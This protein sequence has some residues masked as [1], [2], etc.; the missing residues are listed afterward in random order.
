MHDIRIQNRNLIGNWLHNRKL[1]V[2]RNGVR[3]E[4]LPVMCG[5]PQ[6]SVLG[7]VLFIIHINDIDTNVSSSVHMFADDTKLYSNVC[8]CDQT[9]HPQCDLDKMSAWS[10]KWQMLFNADE[11]KRLHVGHSYHSVT[12]SIGGVEI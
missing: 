8:T 2:V 10:T 4:W 1:R 6:G 5:V 11:C 3:S 7:Q 9:D 12:Y